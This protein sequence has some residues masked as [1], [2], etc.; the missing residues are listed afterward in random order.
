LRVPA[1]GRKAL[2]VTSNGR[3]RALIDGKDLAPE[4]EIAPGVH[5]FALDLRGVPEQV[6]LLI[7]WRKPDG[8][9]EPV[10]PQAFAPP[11]MRRASS[12]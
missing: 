2:R 10:P 8:T 7:E 4:A 5:A 3:S 1:E 12:D 11:R 9:I 6:R